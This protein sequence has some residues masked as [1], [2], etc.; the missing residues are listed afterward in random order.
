MPRGEKVL[1]SVTFSSRGMFAA[2]L[3]LV[4]LCCG[5]SST[6]P[7]TVNR[8]VNINLEAKSLVGARYYECRLTTQRSANVELDRMPFE[9]VR[10]VVGSHPASAFR[11][12]KGPARPMRF[13]RDEGGDMI[14]LDYVPGKEVSL[15]VVGKGG[16]AVLSRSELDGISAIPQNRKGSQQLQGECF[17]VWDV[18]HNLP[19]GSV[20]G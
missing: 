15:L 14:F 16:R 8:N 2:F 10:F 1:V 20:D 7:S 4:L 13:T 5:C 6:P 18:A 17:E 9:V 11:D 3:V 19:G 12:N